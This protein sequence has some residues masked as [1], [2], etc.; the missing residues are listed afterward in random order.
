MAE[1][2]SES[3]ESEAYVQCLL[4]FSPPGM[5]YDEAVGKQVEGI[6]KEVDY[7]YEL[8]TSKLYSTQLH[9]LATHALFL[10]CR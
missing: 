7:M 6:Q 1:P 2:Q 9:F 3:K 5:N 10:G 8:C 4:H